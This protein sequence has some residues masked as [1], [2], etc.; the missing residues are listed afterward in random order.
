MQPPFLIRRQFIR[1][2]FF[3][4][5]LECR[6]RVD[7]H[8]GS[9]SVCGISLGGGKTSGATFLF[10]CPFFENAHGSHGTTCSSVMVV[11]A[12]S[13]CS[14]QH[15]QFFGGDRDTV[16]FFVSRRCL[17]ILHNTTSFRCS[18]LVRSG[19]GEFQGFTDNVWVENLPQSRCS[20]KVVF[21]SSFSTSTGSS[22][23]P[24]E[25]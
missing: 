16:P 7:G 22:P 1:N 25:K 13:Y 11:V 18:N 9:D 19:R 8:P 4:D 14:G 23:S 2:A 17:L 3:L 21:S 6:D 15:F 12:W 10:G 24:F 5:H 20:S